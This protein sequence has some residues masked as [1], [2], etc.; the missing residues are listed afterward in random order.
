MKVIVLAARARIEKYTDF[1]QIPEDWELVFAQG[2]TDAEIFEKAGDAAFIFADPVLPV[3]GSL[4]RSLPN[5]KLIQ[6]EGVGYNRIDLEAVREK[7][8][9]VCNNASANSG[10]VA[11]QIILLILALQRRFMEGARMVYEGGQA[12]A[13]QRFILDGL[14][15]LGDSTVGIVG[16]G[17]I[18]KELARR[19]DGF[20]CRMLYYNRHRLPEKEEAERNVDYCDLDTLLETSDIVSVNLPVTPETTGFI[21]GNFLRRMKKTGILIN[22]ARGEIMDQEAVAQALLDGTIAGAGIDTLAPEPFTLDNPILRLPE[23]VRE[24]KLAVSPHVAG[25]TYHVFHKMHRDSW[26]NLRLVSEGKEPENIVI[27]P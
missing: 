13:K 11:E 12:A 19:L 3:S 21:D 1:S 27:K 23:E 10:A 2:M 8:I 7:G 9:Y 26:K 15:E 5:L 22:T 16:F 18:G 4:I 20:G 17:A 24:K 14:M 25:T 6:S